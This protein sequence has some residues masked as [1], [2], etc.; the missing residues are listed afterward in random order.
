MLAELVLGFDAF[1][2][3]PDLDAAV[4]DPALQLGLVVGLVGVQL[5]GALAGTPWPPAWADDR[6]NGI[7]ER[8]Q[9]G[10]IVGVGSRE[11]DRERDAVSIHHQ[12][13]LG[14]SLAA[15]GGVAAGVLAPFLARTLRLSTLALDQSMAAKFL[16]TALKEVTR[17]IA[18]LYCD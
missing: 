18:S 14:P 7:N 8:K 3:D 15:V 2:G 5:A 13:I 17:C 11:P 6:R 9:V 1:A 10:R 16:E 12:V 4:A